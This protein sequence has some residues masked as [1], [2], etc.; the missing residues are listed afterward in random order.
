M[1]KLIIDSGLSYREMKSGEEYEVCRMIIECFNEFVAP[2]Y[3]HEGVEEFSKYV[4]PNSMRDRLVHDTF[5]FI[6]LDSGM[7][8]GAI[9]IRTNNHVALLFVRKQYHKKVI[10]K[11]L[12]ELA[13]EKCRQAK[14]N[15]DVITVNSSPFAISIYEKLGF[16]K[17]D[18][19]QLINDIRFIPMVLKLN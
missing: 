4:D 14:P 6:A 1:R 3:A 8:I 15:I 10:A 11:R 12:L 18:V 7:I 16:V 5:V 9:E 17:R 19:E 2:D 13:T